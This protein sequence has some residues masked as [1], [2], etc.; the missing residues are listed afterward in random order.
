MPKERTL[1]QEKDIENLLSCFTLVRRKKKKTG[2]VLILY[3]I[4]ISDPFTH[5]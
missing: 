4:N 2:N 3:L 5:N 1:V